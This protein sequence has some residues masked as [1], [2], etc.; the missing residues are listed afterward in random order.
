MTAS[1]HTVAFDGL[2]SVD[3]DKSLT[4]QEKKKQFGEV[5][6]PKQ[7]VDEM[8]DQLPTEL[9]SD[10]NKTWL[11]N[12]CGEGAFLIEVK[13]RLMRGLAQWQPDAVQREQH[14][15]HKQLFGVELQQD[16]WQ[17]CRTNLGLSATGNDGNI[18]CAD[19]L[20]YNYSF[21]KNTDGGYKI[22]D[23]TFEDLFDF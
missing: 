21:L 7:L 8:L 19:G 1:V 3:P 14:I 10:P 9:W 23:N 22:E 13:Q 2:D 20:T 17:R 4:K 11:D 18:V 16:N 15:L 5:F 12:S 6:T